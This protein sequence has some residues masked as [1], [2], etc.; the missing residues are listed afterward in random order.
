VVSAQ[1]GPEIAQRTFPSVVVVQTAGPGG[2]PLN[3]GS[4][5]FVREDIVATNLHVIRGAAKG[6]VRIVGEDRQHEITGVVGQDFE[7]DLALLKIAEVKVTCPPSLVQL[8]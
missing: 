7:R 2:E 8:R 4:G 3:L 1:S 6:F 5:F